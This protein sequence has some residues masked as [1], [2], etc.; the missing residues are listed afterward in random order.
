MYS[1][2]KDDKYVVVTERG[3]KHEIRQKSLMLE[4]T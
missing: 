1:Y 3:E 4:L 2:L